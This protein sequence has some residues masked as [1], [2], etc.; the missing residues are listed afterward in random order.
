MKQTQSLD[1]RFIAIFLVLSVSMT[2]VSVSLVASPVT[3]SQS[4]RLA[5]TQVGDVLATSLRYS[6]PHERI[7][8]QQTAPT[9]SSTSSNSGTKAKSPFIAL[10]LSLLIPGAGQMYNGDYVYGAGFLGVEAGT[11]ILYS[12]YDSD[13]KE[14]TQIYEDFNR[15]H[16]SEQRYTDYLW[17]VYGKRDDDSI[18]ETEISHNLP[19]DPNAQQ[20]FEQTGKYDQ[21]SWGWDDTYLDTGGV[22]P[23]RWQLEWG[24]SIPG[25]Y[26]VRAAKGNNI[27]FS[28]NRLTYETLRD[29]ANRSF[30]NRDRMY[31]VAALNRLV[32][33]MHAF[34]VASSRKRATSTE[35]TGGAFSR[36]EWTP[37]LET[38]HTF[39]DT[40]VMQVRWR[41]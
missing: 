33:G 34:L 5:P 28:A 1:Q 13:G 19:S 31:L 2:V 36:L 21:F 14:R 24:D 18:Q 32:S 22:S 15:A 10:G 27:P 17:Q 41:F 12:K 20:Y 39:A 37:S 11:W 25:K 29:D 8:L 3:H 9:A 4:S 30:E 40:P 38:R 26:G 6:T 35:G 23:L 7:A 16:W